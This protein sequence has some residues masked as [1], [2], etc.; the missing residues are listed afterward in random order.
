MKCCELALMYH[1]VNPMA[2]L[3]KRYALKRLYLGNRETTTLWLPPLIRKWQKYL[4]SC[5]KLDTGTCRIS[6]PE[7]VKDLQAMISCPYDNIIFC[8]NLA[9]IQP[10]GVLELI[11]GLI[12][13][14]FSYSRRTFN[15][16]LVHLSVYFLY[17]MFRLGKHSFSCLLF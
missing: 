16:Y 12:T 10:S 9:A 14:H 4:S 8:I 17:R 5:L 7:V 1:P 6:L 3:L 15:T 11:M 13:P 2:L